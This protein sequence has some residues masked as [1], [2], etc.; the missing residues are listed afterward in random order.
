MKIVCFLEKEYLKKNFLKLDKKAPNFHHLVNV[1]KI[2]SNAEVSF[3][4]GD[5]VEYVF[6][7]KEVKKNEVL[8]EKVREKKHPFP[9]KLKINLVLSLLK[10]NEFSDTLSLVSNIGV[11]KI[12]PL[13]TTKSLVYSN[14]K[15][16]QNVL[17]RSFEIRKDFYLPEITPPLTL[18]NVLEF[19]SSNTFV[20][21]KSGEEF[22]VDDLE[23]LTTVNLIVGPE[24]GFTSEER[25]MLKQKFKFYKVFNATLSSKSFSVFIV[26]VLNYRFNIK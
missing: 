9:F 25:K 12:F 4:S 13:I 15:R 18:E 3:S 6:K 11:N 17:I 22:K 5:L 26:S 21:D 14:L 1:L 19:E 7:V 20:F 24:G 23:G 16:W 2:V 8:F 10:K